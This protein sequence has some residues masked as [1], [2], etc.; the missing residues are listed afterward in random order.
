MGLEDT[1]GGIENKKAEGKHRVFIMMTNHCALQM[2]HSK[3]N[4]FFVQLA[5]PA[6]TE[7]PCYFGEVRMN[8]A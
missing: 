6:P 3:E 8:W 5:P 1:L 4:F 7:V 2:L